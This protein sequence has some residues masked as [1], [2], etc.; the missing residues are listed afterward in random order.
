MDDYKALRNKRETI[1]INI[2]VYFFFL[3]DA[4]NDTM[5]EQRTAAISCHVMLQTDNSVTARE[6]RDVE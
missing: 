4:L 6:W 1:Q 3:L 5:R 2:A